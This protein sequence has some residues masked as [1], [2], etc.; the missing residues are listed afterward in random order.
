[1]R[2][3]C[4]PKCVPSP[5]PVHYTRPFAA[6]GPQRLP[7]SFKTAPALPPPD[8][9]RKNPGTHPG[10][11]ERRQGTPTHVGNRKNKIKSTRNGWRNSAGAARDV[12]RSVEVGW[13]ATKGWRARVQYHFLLPSPDSNTSWRTPPPRST[14][15]DQKRNAKEKN[16]YSKQMLWSAGDVVSSWQCTNRMR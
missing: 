5:C 16:C 2:G 1:M 11:K 7:S 6:K 8:T 10:A 4:L 12:C 9:R 13:R 15:Y 3:A 14:L